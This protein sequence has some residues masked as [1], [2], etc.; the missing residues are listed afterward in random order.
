[1]KQLLQK[2]PNRAGVILMVITA[3]WSLCFGQLAVK[4]ELLPT[5][6][7]APTVLL[8][9]AGAAMIIGIILQAALYTPYQR[10]YRAHRELNLAWC[11]LLLLLSLL[12]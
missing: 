6:S 12:L 1:M 5:H 7:S 11:C 3:V 10:V 8:A 4:Y 2:H 9:T